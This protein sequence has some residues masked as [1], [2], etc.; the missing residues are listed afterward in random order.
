MK[1]TVSDILE[2]TGGRLLA[3]AAE[4]S[5]GTISTDTRALK[6]GQTFLALV[7]E[8][9]DGHDF[10][11]DAVDAGAACLVVQ[12]A[13][14]GA[15]A[16]GRSAAVVLVEDTRRALAD[17]ASAARDRLTCPVIAITGSCGKTTTKEMVRQILSRRF[18]GQAPPASFNNEIGVP[19]TL[20]AA[21]S[22][23]QFVV[24]ELGTNAPGEIGRLAAIARPT[25]G[26]VTLVAPTHLQGL[27]SIEGVADEKAALVDAIPPDGVAILN[28]DDE[29]VAA[30][31]DRC[32]GR[33]VRVGT[34]WEADLQAGHVIQ[35]D[36]GVYFTTSGAAGFELPVLGRHH[37]VL[38]LAAAAAAQEVGV[39]L[40]ESAEALKTYAP[41]PMRLALEAFGDVAVINDAYNASPASMT[42]ALDLLALWPDRRKVFF[43]GDML[44]LG[45]ASREAHA[46]LG[47]AVAEADVAA[48]V[49]VGSET[50][51]T[52]EAAVAAGLVREDVVTVDEARAAAD[53][54]LHVVAEGDVV[55]VKGSRAMGMECVV[56]AMAAAFGRPAEPR[57]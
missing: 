44:E 2:A 32:R 51:A 11:A 49:C 34:S 45:A 16:A 35:T 53:R 43:C 24:C 52:A 13:E 25:V 31:A 36:R 42:M 12:D 37:A 27:K 48:L 19:L 29:R 15:R 30:M 57:A 54:V 22:D 47:K 6:A 10:L 55:L 20:L 39:S 14:A 1:F 41:P 3:G 38:A 23:D 4:A 33:V 8:A 26:I 5:A 56:E 18:R 21:H 46:S 28:A 9:F 40:E 17:V 50:R 7:G